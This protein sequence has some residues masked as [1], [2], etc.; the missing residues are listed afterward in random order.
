M[1]I[2]TLLGAGRA[3]GGKSLERKSVRGKVPLGRYWRV[4]LKASKS[5]LRAL[6]TAVSRALRVSGP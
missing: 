1:K 2:K 3:E 5:V 6:K 4:S